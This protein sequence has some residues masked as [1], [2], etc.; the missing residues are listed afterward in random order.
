MG[1]P[2]N[3][4]AVMDGTREGLQKKFKNI[5]FPNEAHFVEVNLVEEIMEHYLIS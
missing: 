2:V 4:R 3:S 1:Y 5:F